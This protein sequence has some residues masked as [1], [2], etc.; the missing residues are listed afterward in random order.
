MKDL[1][2]NKIN[3]HI[4][5]EC[6]DSNK[7]VIDR[8]ENKNLI[9]N[10]AR[11][12][13]SSILCDIGTAEPISKFVLGTEG[14]IT[15]DYLT[16]K[17]ELQGFVSTR[18]ELFSEELSAY[19]YPIV[20]TNP[21]TAVGNCTIISEPDSGSTVKLNYVGTD[22]Q[23]VIE[24]PEVSANNTGVVVFTEAALYAG[25]NIFSMKCFPGKIKDNTVSLKI[26]WTIKL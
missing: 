14:H 18:T 7:N 23:Y 22:V 9:M 11:I 20:F 3:G 24:I 12:T 15:G 13:L 8:F 2:T 6:L 1:Y 17:T 16:P 19:N 5:I 4:I 21:G 10:T 25:T 26:T